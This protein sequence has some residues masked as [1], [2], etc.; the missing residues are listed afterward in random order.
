M[1]KLNRYIFLGLLATSTLFGAQNSIND[2]SILTQYKDGK[3]GDLRYFLDQKLANKD[4]WHNYLQDKNTTFGYLQNNPNILFC[5]KSQSTLSLYQYKDGSYQQVD[6]YSAFT[7][8]MEGDKQ[9][10]G[11]LRTPVGVYNLLQKLNKV[12]P[13]Y[14][15]MAFVTSYPNL[16][17][18]YQHKT[19]K[20]IWIHG[21]PENEQR[22]NFTKG[23]IAIN[24][25][26]ITALSKKINIHN[27]LLIINEHDIKPV[28]KEELEELLAQ[29]YAWK[30]AW[31]YNDLQTYLSFYDTTFRRFD[32]MNKKTFAQ[33]K[34]RI[35]NKKESKTIQFSQ[36]TVIPYPGEKNLYRITFYEKYKARSFTYNGNKTLIVKLT[37]N[38][39][40]I[41]TEK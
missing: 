24:N 19:G 22:D 14:G 30:N 34:K 4:F 1:M 39:M 10:E 36:M 2:Y 27:T 20:G 9:K 6:H 38:T 35:F 41:I 8:K 31:T 21:V 11:D 32:G 3:I 17:D 29:L 23:C 37:K 16:F 15:P 7:G 5:D 40:H 13:F 18:Q 33:Y 25:D 28:T 12:D 26:N